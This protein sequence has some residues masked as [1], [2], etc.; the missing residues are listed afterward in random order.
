MKE[1]K[2]TSK[3]V[4]TTT[5]KKCFAFTDEAISEILIEYLKEQ[6]KEELDGFEGEV[7]FQCSSYG[8]L[9]EVVVH[10]VKEERKEQ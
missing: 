10:F 7:D 8:H 4:T 9:E 2:K 3:T 1:S 6:Y 5:T